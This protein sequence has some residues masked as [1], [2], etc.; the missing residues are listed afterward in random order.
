MA[1]STRILYAV[2]TFLLCA[3]G[4][5]R[6]HAQSTPDAAAAAQQHDKPHRN[7]LVDDR[8]LRQAYDLNTSKNPQDRARAL[9]LF[10]QA[11]D[12]GVAS[13]QAIVAHA[14][15]YGDFAKNDYAA[16][17]PWLEAA[18]AQGEPW[19]IYMLGWMY[20]QG[21]G[22]VR[23]EQRARE[24]ILRAANLRQP[25]ALLM[26]P[27]L[28]LREG[29]TERD[30]RIATTYLRES[31]DSG[32]PA[33]MFQLAMHLYTGTYLQR[34]YASA[35]SWFDRARE[36]QP[37]AGLWKAQCYALGRGVDADP[38]KAEAQFAALL[39]TA[40]PYELNNFAWMLAASPDENLRDGARAVAIMTAMFEAHPEQKNWMYLDTLAAAY[41]TSERFVEAA[42]TQRAAIAVLGKADEKS[43]A[44]MLERLALYEQGRAYRDQR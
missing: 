3:G 25:S 20:H 43:R 1:K 13:A 33:G 14:Y 10:Q 5:L 8:S 12:Q 34:D 23:D 21:E 40:S 37:Q 4:S 42:T 27:Y 44:S 30:K 31:A 35:F 17:K 28:L 38:V 22:V 9:K 24:L 11:A 39:Q 36:H 18:T 15:I 16:A 26:A 2:A 6:A 7:E 32:N 19:A 41:A 29:V